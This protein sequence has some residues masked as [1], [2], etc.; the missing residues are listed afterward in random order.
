MI[1]YSFIPQPEKS[2]LAFIS[3][4]GNPREYPLPGDILSDMAWQPGGKWIA[5][6]MDIRSDY[7]GRVID[8]KYFLVKSEDF[9]TRQFQSVGVFMNQKI[10]W[11][12]DS[13]NLLWMGTAWQDNAYFIKL[14]EVDAG[15]GHEIDLS[16]AL[17]LK[18]SDYL[19]VNGAA[20]LEQP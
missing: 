7:S 13:S 2:N 5:V 10:I 3:F 19:F 11:S 8:G 17:G 16:A 6:N 4:D 1:A 15:T 20:W 9:G 12:P 14:W 18:N